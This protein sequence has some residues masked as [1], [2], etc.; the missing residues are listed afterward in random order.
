MNLETWS[1][2]DNYLSDLLI[3]NDPILDEVLVSSTKAGLPPHNVSPL[4]GKFLYLL[5]QIRGAKSIL[6]IGTLGAYS[7]IWFARALPESG[8]I[9]TIEADPSHA[10]VA[11]LNIQRSGLSRKIDLR[12]GKAI[13]ICKRTIRAIFC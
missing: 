12:I 6:E 13:D 4:Q 5:T 3:E 1:R 11:K 8:K 2:V 7:S 10:D 9:I